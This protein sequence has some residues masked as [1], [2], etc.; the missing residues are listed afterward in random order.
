MEDDV[1][2]PDGDDLAGD[3]DMEQAGHNEE[4]QDEQKQHDKEEVEVDEDKE[5]DKDEE[6][7]KDKDDG[8]EP[9]TIGQGEMLN[10]SADDVDTMVDNQPIVLPEHGQEMHE[11]TPRP[12]QPAPGPRP[13]TPEPR[14]R[15]RTLE[16]HPLSELEHLR[17]VTPQK[18]RLAVPTLRKAEAARDTS[19]VDVDHPLLCEATCGDS[20]SDVPLPDVSLPNVVCVERTSARIAEQAMVV[21][22]GLGSGSCLVRLCCSN[23]FISGIDYYMRREVFGS[24]RVHMIHSIMGHRACS[25]FASPGV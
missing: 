5:E 13:Q 3:G 22:F 14:P 2:A 17:L 16:T 7:E 15:P 4:E 25:V 24:L 20:L 23:L 6:E 21:S 12:Q 9:R 18:P 11:H 8:K 10:T 19:D 1:D